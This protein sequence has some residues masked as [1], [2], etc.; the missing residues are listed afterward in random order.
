[1]EDK[2]KRKVILKL[3]GEDTI[4]RTIETEFSEEDIQEAVEKIFDKLI[5]S[6]DGWNE[7]KILAILE[8][9]NYIK[10]V[11]KTEIYDITVP[12]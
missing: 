8:K 5:V 3:D 4:V 9:M 2:V 6:D 12:M 7:E 10:I 11:E 1:M